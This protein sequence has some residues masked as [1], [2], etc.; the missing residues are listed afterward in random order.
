M[1][2]GPSQLEPSLR[3]AKTR[4]QG[5]KES[6]NKLNL[7]FPL[8][9]LSPCPLVPLSPCHR[10]SRTMV[11]PSLASIPIQLRALTRRDLADVLAI[12]RA[13]FTDAWSEREF[14]LMLRSPR[15]FAF[16]AEM[17]E[18]VCGYLI[19]EQE[20]RRV[21]VHNLCV[22]PRARR[23]GVASSLIRRIARQLQGR[24]RLV[25]IVSERNVP[26]QLF[27][28]SQGFHVV[29]ILRRLR[30]STDDSYLFEYRPRE[31]SAPFMPAN[32]IAAYL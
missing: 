3:E 11:Q 9:S 5:D 28:R 31:R 17:C 2:E 18:E 25:T 16:V 22:D 12:E 13:S 21:Q 4:G 24:Q 26:A 27:Y 23:R 20:G 7:V 8:A 19:G 10:P 1:E 15:S 29:T 30:S 14:D 32:R 6:S